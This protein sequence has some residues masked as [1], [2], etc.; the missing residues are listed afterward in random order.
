MTGVR[1]IH[2]GRKPITIFTEAASISIIK[3]KDGGYEVMVKAGYD[4]ESQ[5]WKA[6]T[7]PNEDDTGCTV[8]LMK[9]KAK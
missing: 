6:M 5:G 7:V 1:Y 3:T 9:R 8:L 4:H 2:F